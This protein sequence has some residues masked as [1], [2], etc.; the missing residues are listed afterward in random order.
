MGS[1]GRQP[2]FSSTQKNPAIASAAQM[3]PRN[4]H[5]RSSIGGWI[6]LSERRRRAPHQPRLGDLGARGIEKGDQA[7]QAQARLRLLAPI[8]DAPALA[9]VAPRHAEDTST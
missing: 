2:A 3:T 9:Q 7:E 4:S 8:G 5:A 1:P 6:T